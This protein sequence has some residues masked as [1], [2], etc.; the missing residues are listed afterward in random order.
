[1]SLA[2]LAGFGLHVL[3]LQ[4]SQ[5]WNCPFREFLTYALFL[6]NGDAGPRRDALAAL[7]LR[8]PDGRDH[9]EEMPHAE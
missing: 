7:M 4:P 9:G 1:L 3:R 6:T 8:F 5:I 2:R